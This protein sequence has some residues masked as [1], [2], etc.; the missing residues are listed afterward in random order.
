MSR[1]CHSRRPSRPRRSRRSHRCR[2]RHQ[3][4]AQGKDDCRSGSWSE[5]ARA[6]R[7][8]TAERFKREGSRVSLAPLH[9]LERTR[10]RGAPLDGRIHAQDRGRASSNHCSSS[11][12]SGAILSAAMSSHP[13]RSPTD[14][15]HQ[16]ARRA[17]RAHER[18]PGGRQRRAAPRRL[19]ARPGD[20]GARRGRRRDPHLR[21]GVSRSVA[22]LRAVGLDIDNA[23]VLD[24]K[25]EPG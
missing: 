21:G 2:G 16:A 3:R 12:V 9:V 20:A 24:V 15:R 19:H 13:R 4:L 10:E 17:P 25:H 6:S 5:S 11:G 18:R 8:W 1:R 22:E 23:P 7:R 14:A